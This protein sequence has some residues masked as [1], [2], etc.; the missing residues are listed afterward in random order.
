MIELELTDFESREIDELSEE[1]QAWLYEFT[2]RENERLLTGIEHNNPS[3]KS[4]A[5]ELLKEGYYC[6]S[7]SL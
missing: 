1:V 5:T 2:E 4:I 3:L 6:L 7:S